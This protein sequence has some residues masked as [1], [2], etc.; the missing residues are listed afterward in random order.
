MIHR[1]AYTKMIKWAIL[2]LAYGYLVYV[3]YQFDEYDLVLSQCKKSLRESWWWLFPVFFLLPVNL[4]LEAKKWQL[5][6]SKLEPHSIIESLKSV[7]GGITTAFFTPNRIGEFPGRVLFLSPQNRVKGVLLGGVS[8]L[9]QTLVI[10]LWGVPAAIVLLGSRFAG[11]SFGYFLT[12]AISFFLLICVYVFLPKI[13]SYF[14][15]FCKGKR[16][17]NILYTLSEYRRVDLFNVLLVATLRYIVFSAQFFCMLQFFCISL[18]IWQ[19]VLAIAANYLFV[20]FAPAFAFSEGAVRASVAVL[21]F[22]L[23]TQNQLAVAVAGISIW[24]VNFIFPMIFGSYFV[25]KIKTK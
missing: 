3:L 13:A 1:E 2:V 6:L 21:I 22:G 14:M 20:T 24:V 10:L 9:S 16:F 7:L 15:R 8:A 17:W 11:Q 18:D 12:A 25:A 5:L 19:A 23:F 4:F